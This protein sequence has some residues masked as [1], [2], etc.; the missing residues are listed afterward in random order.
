MAALGTAIFNWFVQYGVF[1]V[2]SFLGWAL[3]VWLLYRDFKKKDKRDDLLLAKDE[4]IA[5]LTRQ[6]V[7]L[8]ESRVKDMRETHD[9]YNAVATSTIHMLDKLAT[10]LNV[11]IDH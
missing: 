10:A 7:N 2:L 11:R 6:I 3:V 8:G 5:D 1:G 9:D 4:T